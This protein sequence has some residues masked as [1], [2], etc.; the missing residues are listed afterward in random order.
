MPSLAR[1][2]RFDMPGFEPTPEYV[3]EMK[4]FGI[5]PPELQL[6]CDTIDVYETD[7][8]YWQSLVARPIAPSG[9]VQRRG[10]TLR[11]ALRSEMISFTDHR[12]RES[13][14]MVCRILSLPAPD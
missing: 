1:R 14:I 12:P 4:R 8:A 2:K 13:K 7:R 5:L 10:F 11:H 6:G 3:R 9:P